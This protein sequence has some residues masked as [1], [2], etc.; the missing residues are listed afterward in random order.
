MGGGTRR[1]FWSFDCFPA[2]GIFP[3]FPYPLMRKNGKMEKSVAGARRA[4]AIRA[5]RGTAGDATWWAARRR[6]LPGSPAFLTTACHCLAQAVPM[7]RATPG[8]ASA[9]QWHTGSRA[10]LGIEKCRLNERDW[11]CFSD[12]GARGQRSSCD[13]QESWSLAGADGLPRGC[14]PIYPVRAHGRKKW[15]SFLVGGGSG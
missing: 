10:A 7:P 2:A 14:Q 12:A 15:S 5:G 3:F 8:T 1:E 9:K 11:I 4:R 6:W 13:C